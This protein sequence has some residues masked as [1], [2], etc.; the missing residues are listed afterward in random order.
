MATNIELPELS[1]PQLP[2]VIARNE[3]IV[4]K[5]FWQKLRKL[6]GNVPFAEDLAAAYYCAVDPATPSRVKGILFA[7]LAYF[8]LPFDVIPDFIAGL[9]FTDD[10]AVLAMAIGLVSRHITQE[11]RKRAR[12]ALDIAEPPK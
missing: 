7:A 6:A 9:G 11:H 2:A 8:V 3:R 12:R 10:A 5:S 4:Q 1:A